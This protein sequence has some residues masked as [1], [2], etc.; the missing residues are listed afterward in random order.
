MIPVEPHRALGKTSLRIPPLVFSAAPLANACRITPEQTRIA[1]CVEWFKHSR[2][3]VIDVADGYDAGRA[4][5]T[6]DDVSRRAEIR[7]E[8]VIICRRLSERRVR[9]VGAV[10]AWRESAQLLDGRCEP[11]LVAVDGLDAHL[12]AADSAVERERRLR[13]ARTAL[14]P[15]IGLR[16]QGRVKAVGLGVQDWRA[17]GGLFDAVPFDWVTLENGITPLRHPPELVAL[18]KTLAG[19]GVGI[20]TASVFHDG[21]L[22][23]G[24]RI[25]GLPIDPNKECH[26]RL[27]TWR[28]SFAA[29]C[30]GY[31]LTPVEACIQFALAAP[32]V[33]AVIVNT[34]HAERMAE[35]VRAAGRSVPTQFWAA[36]KEEGLIDDD[37]TM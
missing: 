2:P 32:G 33:A 30:H 14:E 11:T 18:L 23:G 21:F 26:Q 36:M 31:G 20:I 6:I 27:L 19:R 12:A 28:T 22:V 17:I 13:E 35:L 7:S 34:S 24:S 10:E 1:L 5:A 3:A 29:L 15:L 16:Q 37:V 9:R 8:D 25:D 4:L